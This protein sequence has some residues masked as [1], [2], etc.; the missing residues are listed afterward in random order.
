[1]KDLA[2]LHDFC[3]AVAQFCRCSSAGAG[4]GCRHH[5]LWISTSR[6]AFAIT[7]VALHVGVC[8]QVSASTLVSN[9]VVSLD[10]TAAH[11]F[12]INNVGRALPGA[13]H[14]FAVVVDRFASFACANHSKRLVVP[15]IPA[16]LSFSQRFFGVAIN[17]VQGHSTIQYVRLDVYLNAVLRIATT[18]STVIVWFAFLPENV[19]FVV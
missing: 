6:G 4:G 7:E 9:L 10:P 13:R 8:H 3:I 12:A 15:C 2:V 5:H 1:V 18:E 16:L 14:G 19:Q 11:Y 17:V